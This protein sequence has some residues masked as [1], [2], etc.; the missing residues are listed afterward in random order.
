[1]HLASI[2]GDREARWVTAEEMERRIERARWVVRDVA[3][4]ELRL[5][6]PAVVP[7]RTVVVERPPSSGGVLGR[8]L[9]TVLR[10]CDEVSVVASIHNP[11][12]AL[13]HAR[14]NRARL[15]RLVARSGS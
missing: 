2:T 7:T 11:E 3:G 4:L 9:A 15:D 8:S 13:L 14:D 10:T 5:V 6:P 1:V 12:I